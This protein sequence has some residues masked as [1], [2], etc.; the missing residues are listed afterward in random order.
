MNRQ[1]LSALRRVERRTRLR[2]EWTAGGIDYWFFDYVPKG[3]RPA[4]G[5]HPAP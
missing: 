3:A 5:D 4:P 2:S 1:L